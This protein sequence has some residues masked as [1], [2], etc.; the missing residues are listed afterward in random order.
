MRLS[1]W[2]RQRRVQNAST[3]ALVLLGPLLAG[4]T[5]VILGPLN[6]GG[7]APSLRIVLLADLVYILVVAALVLQRV[8]QLIVA[9]RAR[10]AGSRLH[11][12]LTGVFALLALIPT[13]LVAVF[14]VLSINIGLEGWF[15]DRVQNV[16]RTSLSAAQAYEDEH[17]QELTRDGTALAGYLNLE[18][19]RYFFMNSG[20]L[21]Q[22][23]GPVTAGSGASPITDRT[24]PDREFRDRRVGRY[25][26]AGRAIL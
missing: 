14:A 12:R 23:L 6:Q 22:G 11:L 17:R 8:A 21:R 19:Q 9:R 3:L 5:F 2:R 20:Q 24:W 16:L 18:R 15:S 13:V 4:I 1:R 25:R 26:G 7:Q 10:S